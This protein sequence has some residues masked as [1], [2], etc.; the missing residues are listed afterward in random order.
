MEKVCAKLGPA[1][2]NTFMLDLKSW[3]ARETYSSGLGDPFTPFITGVGCPGEL[4]P[5]RI[6]E[7]TL[8]ASPIR[9]TGS[10]FWSCCLCPDGQRWMGDVGGA[11]LQSNPVKQSLHGDHALGVEGGTD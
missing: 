7:V 8:P 11:D 6:D 10:W 1:P 5:I 4:P 9:S 3:G 2:R